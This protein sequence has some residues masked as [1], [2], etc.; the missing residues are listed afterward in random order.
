MK[1]SD[2]KLGQFFTPSHIVARMLGLRRN[3]GTILEPASGNGAFLESLEHSAVAIECDSSLTDDPRTLFIDYFDYSTEHKFDS[4]VGNPPYVRY[5]EIKSKTKSKLPM[6]L[7]DCRSN[8]YLFFIAKSIEH[9]RPNG[10]LIF[11]TPRD[12]LKATSAKKLNEVLY[13]GGTMTHYF[14]LGDTAVFED[15]T[16]NCAIWR[17]EKNNFKR[18][19]D[20]G[21][22]FQCVN[23][24][25]YFGESARTTVKDFFDVKVGAVSGADDVFSDKKFGCTD[26]VCS[27]TVRD[28]K[29]RSMIYDRYDRVLEPHKDRLLRRK[30][31]RFDERNWW[32]WGRK[33]CSRQGVRIYVNSKTRNN[34]PFFVS[35]IEAYDGSVLALFPKLGVEPNRAAQK[36]NNTDWEK[37]AFVCDGRLLF[38]Q[39]SL[40]NAPFEM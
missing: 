3:F 32:E 15:A 7:F 22:E 26:M 12:F 18:R 23:G 1:N 2:P 8:L 39:R 16:P 17:W 31:R 14:E 37:L 29:L 38:S 35:E 19:M 33:Y 11:I 10:E 30:I 9:L 13:R 36:L 5:Q 28:G 25:I 6:E 40:A 24:Q 20:T 34:K 27:T 4:I 21:G